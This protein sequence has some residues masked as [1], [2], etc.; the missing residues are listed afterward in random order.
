M[1]LLVIADVGGAETRHIGDEAMLEA[2]LDAFRR[3]IPEVAFTVVSRDPAW[4]AAR[5]GVNAVAPFGFPRDLSA[6]AERG[7]L[8]ERLLADAACQARG[9]TTTDATS[10]AV[11]RADGLVVSGGGNLSASW[12]D[13]LYERAAL[14]HLARNFGKPAV[15][16][17]Q[18][19]GP[20]LESDER[21][22][23][24]ETLPSARFVGLRELPSAALALELGVSPERIWYQSDD[25]LFLEGNPESVPIFSRAGEPTIAVT[26]DPQ[27]RATGGKVFGSLV[28]QLRGL[29]EATGAHLILIPHVYGNESAT[30]P[31]DLTEARLIAEGIGLSQTVV[32]AGLDAGQ[33]RRVTGDAAM[34]I[35]SRYHPIVFGLG[36][37]VP[38]IGIFGDEYC[39]IKLQG[40]LA[41]A[42]LERWAITYDDVTRGELLTK[43]L[44]LWHARGEARRELESR[45]EAWREESR[46]RWPTVLRALD[47]ATTLPPAADGTMFGR[48]MRD[49]A[50]ALAS[51][52]EARRQW[53][54][55]E[56]KSFERLAARFDEAQRRARSSENETGVGKAFRRYASA[57]RSRLHGAAVSED[58]DD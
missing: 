37:A 36:A 21:R 31:S 43:A 13:L 2:N 10:D 52:L 57:A 44:K 38:S 55:L 24:A 32:A 8:L 3:L 40:A 33:T 53:W 6:G 27:V 25:A 51:A 15:V 26:I 47:P 45:R 16:L 30:A 46:E 28:S 48:P 34:V 11:A 42:R 41:H 9:N 20:R 12:P 29:S 49:V 19:I 5:Y 17:G 22:L 23:L 58:P 7:A 56:R 14:L 35:S 1:R 4:A 18:T 50:P 54:E 39:R